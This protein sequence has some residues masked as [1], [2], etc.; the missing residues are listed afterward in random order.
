MR[1]VI[2]RMEEEVV[3]LKVKQ[4]EDGVNVEGVECVSCIAVVGGG[5]GGLAVGLE[6]DL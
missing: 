1:L 5:V 3:G 6:I 4:E 2:G